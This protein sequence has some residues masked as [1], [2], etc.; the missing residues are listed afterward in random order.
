MPNVSPLKYDIGFHLRVDQ[1]F[2]D[3]L[4]ELCRLEDK[5]K[6]DVIRELVMEALGR[7]KARKR[8]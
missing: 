1:E 3:A 7:A 8:K 6:S 4:R 5:S 2:M